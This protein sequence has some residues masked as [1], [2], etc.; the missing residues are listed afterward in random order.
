V[1]SS[2]PTDSIQLLHSCTISV[3]SSTGQP[4]IY[5]WSMLWLDT[6]S[7]IHVSDEMMRRNGCGD[8]C[9]WQ[10]KNARGMKATKSRW[11]RILIEVLTTERY[12]QWMLVER[13]DIYWML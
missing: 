13:I 5:N 6:S 7:W 8:A 11:A 12:W 1:T 9:D 4:L 2:K 10:W 3:G